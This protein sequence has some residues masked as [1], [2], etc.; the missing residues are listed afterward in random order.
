MK[1]TELFNETILDGIRRLDKVMDRAAAQEAARK[2]FVVRLE[3]QGYV[4]AVN[5][6]ALSE[7]EAKASAQ[8]LCPAYRVFSCEEVN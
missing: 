4:V 6:R 5:R 3:C 8:R 1:K 2:D 7:E